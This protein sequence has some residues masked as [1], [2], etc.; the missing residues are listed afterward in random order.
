MR[1][2]VVI[3]C[4]M[5]LVGNAIAVNEKTIYGYV[6]KAVLVEN[7]LVVSAKL[8]TGAKT[9]SLSAIKITETQVN[10]KTFLTFLVPTKRGN[11]P[12]TCE[13]AGK[14]QIKTR[15]GESRIHS[16]LKSTMRRPVVLIKI[17]LD[18]K[19]RLIRVN[20]TNRKRFIYPLLLGREAIM[21]FDGIID[22]S[23]KYTTENKHVI[24]VMS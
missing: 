4:W 13:Y 1:F 21:D 9:A 3:F 10:G 8:D 12:F 11:I 24:K 22:P 19:E 23:L 7:S 14:V 15:V 6:E 16:I 20:L 17:A 18:G 2:L 5:T